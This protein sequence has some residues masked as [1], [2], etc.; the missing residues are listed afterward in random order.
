MVRVFKLTFLVPLYNLATKLVWSKIR[1]GTGG[2]LK[3]SVCG[4]GTLPM[5]LE[6]FFE[7][8]KIDITVGYGLT[9][10]SAVIS[11]RFFTHNVRGSAGIPL[12]GELVKVVNPET[13]D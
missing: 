4:G 12:P 13:H 5:Y 7:C 6:D 8:A 9:E 1:E 3:V 10:T 11:T 2:R